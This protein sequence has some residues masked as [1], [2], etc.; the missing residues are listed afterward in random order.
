MASK[1]RCYIVAEKLAGKELRLR[2]V[3]EW[4]LTQARPDPTVVAADLDGLAAGATITF[5]AVGLAAW[6]ST[7][8]A[9]LVKLRQMGDERGLSFDGRALPDG[10]QRLLA[11]A[12]TVPERK[13]AQRQAVRP[14]FLAQVG[15]EA[16]DLSRSA[17]DMLSF[18]GAATMAAVALVRGH[19]RLRLAEFGR[20]VQECGV[21]A[22]PI[23]SLI[24]MLV[25]LILAYVGA[26]QLA[27]FGAE[28]YVANLVGI[29]M[30]RVMGAVMA[31][32]I[33]AGRTGAA[34][35]AQI[36]TMQVNEEIDALKTLGIS[37][38]QFLVLPRM[39][40][41]TLMMP[42]LCLYADLMGIVGGLLVGVLVLDLNLLEY[43]RQTVDS[44]HLNHLWIGLF[45][46]ALFG[47]LVAVAGCLRGLQCERS[48]SAV[49]RAA[50]SAVVTG[51]VSI[52]LATALVTISCNVLGI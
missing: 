19:Q 34:F 40:A 2:P 47:V 39:L 37:P 26:V 43:Y 30:V 52:V 23:V 38:M 32:I 17:L 45:Q 6:D 31:G 8:L 50:T 44:V 41:L 12:E 9:F 48:A 4:R 51:I 21:G 49:G 27:L 13:G 33:M 16:E 29:A 36:G 18:I 15:E 20:L 14:S 25:G 42:L 10:V 46:A 5:D 3:G 24:S 11:L 22:L 28:I 35:A 1:K 7:F